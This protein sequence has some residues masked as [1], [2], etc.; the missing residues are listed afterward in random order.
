MRLN[1]GRIG[2][3]HGIS[4]EATIE[5]RTDEPNERFAVGAVLDTDLGP[6]KI[7]SARN[8]NGVLLLAFNGID[9]RSEIEKFRDVLLYSDVDVDQA[10]GEDDFHKQ[11]LIGLTALLED[12]KV[13]GEV[14]DVINLPAQDCLVIK[15]SRGETLLPFVKQLVPIVDLKGKNVI[16]RPQEL[17]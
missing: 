13:F 10:R 4:G 14:I 15:T 16:V 5:V 11:Q 3:A 9:N 8:H 17:K 1:V 6:L 12:G 7:S 2:R